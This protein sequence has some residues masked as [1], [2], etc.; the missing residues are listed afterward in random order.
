[1]P[2]DDLRVM[3][4]ATQGVRLIKLDDEDEIASVAKV[5]E[6]VSPI[7]IENALGSSDSMESSPIDP[8]LNGHG[9]ANDADIT[10]STE[11]GNPEE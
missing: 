11:E 2:V 8:E 1:M 9:D 3:G 7:E 6:I 5:E 10:D 4:R